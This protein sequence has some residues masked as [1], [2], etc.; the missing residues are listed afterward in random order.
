MRYFEGSFK[1]FQNYSITKND[2]WKWNI[3]YENKDFRLPL[4]IRALNY[5]K[6]TTNDFEL[7]RDIALIWMH[8]C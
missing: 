3:E 6:L 1:I 4:E 2:K 7:L 8:R 5:Q